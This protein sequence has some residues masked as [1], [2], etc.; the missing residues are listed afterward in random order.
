MPHPEHRHIPLGSDGSHFYLSQPEE[1]RGY[2]AILDGRAA[3]R[4]VK[5]FDA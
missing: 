1:I 4:P 5:T 2:P 3:D